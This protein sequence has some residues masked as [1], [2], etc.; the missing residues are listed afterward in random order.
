MLGDTSPILPFSRRSSRKLRWDAPPTTNESLL[1]AAALALRFHYRT[2]ALAINIWNAPPGHEQ[3]LVPSFITLFK[4]STIPHPSSPSHPPAL[5]L[6][7]GDAEVLEQV[8]AASVAPAVLVLSYSEHGATL[9]CHFDDTVIPV[10]QAGWF[11]IHVARGLYHIQRHR[12]W[13]T[14]PSLQS[15]YLQ[16]YVFRSIPLDPLQRYNQCPPSTPPS[17]T[18]SHLYVADCARL[19]PL[20]PAISFKRPSDGLVETFSYA[21][22][23][24]AAILVKKSLQDSYR[25]IGLI[26]SLT[27]GPVVLAILMLAASMYGDSLVAFGSSRPPSCGAWIQ[28]VCPEVLSALQTHSAN[29]DMALYANDWELHHKDALRVSFFPDDFTVFIY[30]SV[31]EE[32]DVTWTHLS[33]DQFTLLISSQPRWSKFCGDRGIRPSVC[34]RS[35][36]LTPSWVEGLWETFVVCPR[37]ISLTYPN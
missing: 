20:A 33:H 29:P 27:E 13:S 15:G 12:D 28:E 10:A 18:F 11:I 36:T 8:Q 4:E 17:H 1:A 7:H 21:G 22:V 14:L 6:L 3:L 25:S 24:S 23:V 2:S 19:D 9:S 30:P 31:G 16:E 37:Y 26:P 5:V 34:F 35:R 32:Q